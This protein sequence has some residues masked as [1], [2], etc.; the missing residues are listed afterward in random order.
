MPDAAASFRISE[1]AKLSRSAPI[2]LRSAGT[3][4]AGP[5]DEDDR[6]IQQRFFHLAFQEA[7]VHFVSQSLKFERIGHGD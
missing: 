6:R 4:P 7:F 5:D 3:G 2:L 1:N